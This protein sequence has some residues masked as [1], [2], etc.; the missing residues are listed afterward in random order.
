MTRGIVSQCL[1]LVA[2]C[3]SSL[4]PTAANGANAATFNSVLSIA[5]GGSSSVDLSRLGLQLSAMSSYAVVS[6][7]LLG[8]GLYLFAITPLKVEDTKG[9]PPQSRGTRWATSVFA[10]VV[11]LNIVTSLHTAITFNV[12]NLYANSALG[13]GMDDAYLAF[14]DA[15]A[16]QKLRQSAFRSFVVA[17]QSFKASFGLSVF[18]KTN[19]KHRNI[20]TLI[21]V[22]VMAWSGFQ[23]WEMVHIASQTIYK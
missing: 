7:L 1:P 10:C 17:I 4:V 3:S 15:P 9:Q 14:W 12:M 5:R 8:S 18:L 2:K 21:A 13:R 19:G 11:A 16:I 6:S 22:L 20:A 23:F